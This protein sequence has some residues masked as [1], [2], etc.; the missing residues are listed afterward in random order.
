MGFRLSASTGQHIGDRTEQQD[1]VEV[2]PSPRGS[3]AALVVVA[4][5]IGGRT[6]GSL[7]AEQ[8]IS[9]ARHLF[10][11]YSPFGG[12]PDTLFRSLVHE[13]HT[14]IRLTALS[15]DR[16]PH[17]TIA[18]LLLTRESVHWMN[19]GDTR[20]YHIRDGALK[21]RTIDHTVSQKMVEDGVL[22]PDQACNHPMSNVLTRALGTDQEPRVDIYSLP[23][24]VAG[25]A[26]V[27][28]SDG[29]WGY[30]DDDEMGSLVAR[31]TARMASEIL[32]NRAR[33][34]SQGNGDNCSIAIVK[35][36]HPG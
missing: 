9:T 32:I 15:A 17:S 10:A 35:L 28:C 4:D 3:G 1:R 34:R 22:S 2:I 29:L 19:V 13:A 7:A 14:V 20:V 18:A 5:G 6:G 27:L 12:S 16:E 23:A 26:F 31:N 8:V 36:E 25:D 24:P 30:I 11:D 33:A 21:S